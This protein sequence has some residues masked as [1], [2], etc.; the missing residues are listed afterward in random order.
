MKKKIYKNIDECVYTTQLPN[1]MTVYLLYKPGFV[2]KNA[3]IVT[4]FGHF[5]SIRKIEVNENKMKIPWGA[6]HF[7]E[8]RM[9]SLG[10]QDASDLFSLYG[11]TSNAYTTYEKTAYYFSCEKNF[12]ECLTILLKMMDSFSSTDEQIENEKSIILQ[13][14]NMYKEEPSHIINRVILEQAYLKHPISVDIIGTDETIQNTNKEI[15]DA[16]F[17][18]F[19]DPSNLTLVVC[20]DIDHHELE[21][22]LLKNLLQN[23]NTQ[24]ITPLK[25]KEPEQVKGEFKEIFLS[26]IKIP[27][28][29]LL[30]KLKPVKSQKDKDKNYFCYYFILD[31]LFSSSGKLSEKWLQNEIISTLLEYSICSNIDLDYIIFYNISEN[32]KLVVDNIKKVF[33]GKKK[34]NMTQEEFE[35]LKRSHYGYTLRSYESVNGL[36]SYFVYDLFTSTNDFFQ[37]IEE[38]RQLTLEDIQKAFENVCQAVTTLV[39]LR[40]E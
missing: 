28:F 11:A 33:D 26:T 25:I 21:K 1:Q 10:N 4:K 19:Y 29:A 40:G 12:Y 27:R 14:A 37:E 16:I 35:G 32:I 6:A 13:E 36:C 23:K 8:H 9:F 2:E 38:V 15:L 3:Y 39:V 18:T 34:L 7:L 20:G 5:D 17:N 31:Y 24:K 30:F 22:F